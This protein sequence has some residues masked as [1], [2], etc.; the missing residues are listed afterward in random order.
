[1]KNENEVAHMYELWNWI[2][3]CDRCTQKYPHWMISDRDWKKG[4][5][6]MSPKFGPSKHLCKQCFEEY[7][8]SPKYFTVDE[9]IEHQ[10]SMR[11]RINKKIGHDHFKPFTA[12]GLV[13]FRARLETLWEM[14]S[15]YSREEREEFI[16]SVGWPRGPFHK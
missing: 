14:P 12:K 2:Y 9:Y 6:N 10:N 8:E 1:M 15:E 4:V 3:E 13:R 5:K 11:E 7:N 16:T